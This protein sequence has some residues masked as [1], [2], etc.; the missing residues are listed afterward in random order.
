[1]LLLLLLLLPLL[2]LVVVVLLL[3]LLVFLLLLVRCGA[4]I[5]GR[6]GKVFI[7]VIYN[8]FYFFGRR[9]C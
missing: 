9:V 4:W 1:M 8:L 5:G 2:L 3:L 7:F 6:S